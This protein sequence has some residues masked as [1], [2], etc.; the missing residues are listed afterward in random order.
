M[1]SLDVAKINLKAFLREPFNLVLVFLG[2]PAVILAFMVFMNAVPGWYFHFYVH[3]TRELGA[4]TGTLFSTAFLVGLV[5]LFQIISAIEADRRLVASGY[6][7]RQIILGRILTIF[8]ISTAVS[9]ISL[10]IMLSFIGSRSYLG[11]YGVLLAS[12]MIYGLMGILVGAVVPKKLEASLILVFLADLDAFMATGIVEWDHV[13]V[14]YLPLNSP[15][16]L[17]QDMVFTGSVDIYHLGFSLAY[18]V[19]FAAL[20]VLAFWRASCSEEGV[21]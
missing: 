8:V 4:V 21:F 6:P 18:L 12:G 15:S 2:L 17:M 14:N 5:G 9:A 10:G 3:T 16:L 13:L 19:I 20:A 7:I 11:V 1:K